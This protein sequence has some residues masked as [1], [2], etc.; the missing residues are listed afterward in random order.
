[1]VQPSPIPPLLAGEETVVNHSVEPEE[2]AQTQPT[3]VLAQLEEV[4]DP[5]QQLMAALELVGVEVE[6]VRVVLEEPALPVKVDQVVEEVD[7]I[8]VVVGV[9]MVEQVTEVVLLV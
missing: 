8:V 2:L 1:M 9:D 6:L 4:V 7:Y 5:T 3:V